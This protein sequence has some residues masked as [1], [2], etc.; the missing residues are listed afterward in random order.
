MKLR[1]VISGGQTGADRTG[2]ECAAALGLET[3]GTMP[4]GFRTEIGSGCAELWAKKYGL[5]EHFDT[6]YVP[7]TRQNAKDADVTVWFGR[8]NSP[9][10][11]CTRKACKDW[12]KPMFD[13]PTVKQLWE[14][15][16]TYEVWNVAGNR[17]STNKDVADLVKDAFR[18]LFKKF[19]FCCFGEKCDFHKRGGRTTAAGEVPE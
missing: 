5:T 6:S 19:C 14:L 3:G 16:E 12:G 9:G 10:Y 1:K 13:N 18:L 4:K 2:V 15:S 17:A 8:T 11:F 7:R